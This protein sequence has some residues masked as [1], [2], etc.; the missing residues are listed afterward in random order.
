MKVFDVEGDFMDPAG[1]ASRTHD[2][3]CNNA[4]VLEL[5]DL[6]T[7]LEIFQLREKYFDDAQG[8]KTALEQRSDKDYAVCANAVAEQA[9][10]E[11]HDL[12]AVGV[13]I[14]GLDGKTCSFPY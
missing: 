13:P 14:R 8:L 9:F 7:C 2:F 5:R 4:P 1:R 12:F 10:S 3:T 6:P 11:L